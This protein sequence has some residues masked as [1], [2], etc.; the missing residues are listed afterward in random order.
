MKRIKK[1]IHSMKKTPNPNFEAFPI[2][3]KD[4]FKW[5]ATL[6]GPEST[7][8]QNGIFFLD[9]TI[10]PDYPFKP[11]KVTFKT[12][13]YH[14]NVDASGSICLDII[15]NSWSPATTLSDI[16]VSIH[17]LMKFPN[18]DKALVPEIGKV[19]KEDVNEFNKIATEWTD[20]FAA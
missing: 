19:L 13:V 4:L 16:L 10:P 6:M 14:P 1:E 17:R 7:P 18:A 3:D 9:I 11:P 12:K 5:Q 2:N 20:K 8:Y 15:K